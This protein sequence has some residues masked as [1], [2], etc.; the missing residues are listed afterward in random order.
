MNRLL[1]I[2]GHNL[3]FQIFFGIQ[4]RL[5]KKPGKVSPFGVGFTGAMKRIIRFAKPTHVVVIFDGEHENPRR[6]LFPAYKA[7]RPDY[8]QLPDDENPYLQLPAVRDA[9]DRMKIKYV[10][11][12][13]VEADDMIAVCCERFR[14]AA[15]IIVCSHDHDFYQLLGSRVRLM[16]YS[17]KQGSYYDEKN[18]RDEFHISPRRFADYKALTGDKSDNI[19]GVRGV[20]SVS[21]VRLLNRFGGVEGIIEHTA[22]VKQKKLRRCL[23]EGTDR[24]RLNYQLV[25]LGGEQYE[26]FE[27]PW[28]LA[29]LAFTMPDEPVKDNRRRQKPKQGEKQS[30]A[31]SGQKPKQERSKRKSP[32]PKSTQT[33]PPQSLPEQTAPIPEP[34]PVG[35]KAEQTEGANVKPVGSAKPRNKRRG[36]RPDRPKPRVQQTVQEPGQVNEPK[37]ARVESNPARAEQKPKPERRSGP[38]SKPEPPKDVRSEPKSD[39]RPGHKNEQRPAKQPSGQAKKPRGSRQNNQKRRDRDGY[40]RQETAGDRILTRKQAWDD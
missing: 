38:E 35:V 2:D 30:A 31:Q 7:N 8:S 29:D 13:T 25:K 37:P 28:K 11:T 1:I 26:S 15:D 16:N 5:K 17:G 10:E 39:D 21:A 4:S 3:H 18:F 32:Q 33:K 22:E 40:P 24:M 12:T 36:R 6:A 9:L 14:A 27:L 20:G 34:K 23:V 19:P